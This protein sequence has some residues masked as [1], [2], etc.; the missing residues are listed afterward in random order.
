[1]LDVSD[2]ANILSDDANQLIGAKNKTTFLDADT[3]REEVK[4]GS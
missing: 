2:Y 3:I 1:M 4:G